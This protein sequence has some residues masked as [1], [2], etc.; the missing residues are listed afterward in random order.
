M[1]Q[2]CSSAS[3]IAKLFAENFSKNSNLDDSGISLLVFPCSTNLKLHISVT[4]KIVK[5]VIIMNL[6]S[7]EAPGPD[8]IPLLVFRNYE[9]DLSHILAE[10]FMCLKESFFSTF[11]EGLSGGPCI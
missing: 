3:D 11:L 10:L 5:K 1:A 8:C 7:S 4:L 6:D 9:P 2:W